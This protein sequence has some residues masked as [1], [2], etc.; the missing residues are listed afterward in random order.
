MQMEIQCSCGS[1]FSFDDTRGHGCLASPVVC[2]RCGT[3]CTQQVDEFL[4]QNLDH[5]GEPA[6]KGTVLGFIKSRNT[7]QETA[8]RPT[9]AITSEDEDTDGV[10][11]DETSVARLTVA[12]IAALGVGALGA[13]GWLYI[14]KLTGYEIGLVA[15]GLG[16]LVGLTSRLIAPRG[17]AMLATVATVAALMAIFGGQILV[18]RWLVQTGVDEFVSTAY[19]HAA[20]YAIK[21][22]TATTPDVQR[23][24]AAEFALAR[25]VAGNAK[26][27]PIALYQHYQVV[28]SGLA[29]VG[30]ISHGDRATVTFAQRAELAD[31][32]NVSDQELASFKK[33]V[34]PA[35]KRLA[36][37]TPDEQTY[38]TTLRQEIAS[39][40]T[41]SSLVT[42]AIGPYTILWLVLGLGTAWR[43]ARVAGLS[44]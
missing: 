41:F 25:T 22:F 20:T 31:G 5:T 29:F 13:L 32:A 10:N 19:E 17:H 23:E 24:C 4:G 36:D 35:L 42:N 27:D 8:E 1:L 26:K 18:S 38:T 3:D 34:L 16:G 11:G 12:G 44:Y 33:T 39:R 37:G 9:Q 14:A 30:M 21:A 43:I 40:V 28:D 2:T 6:L 15:W 7:R